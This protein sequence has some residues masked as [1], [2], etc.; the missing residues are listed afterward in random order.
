VAKVLLYMM[1]SLAR[2]HL[3]SGDAFANLVLTSLN[4]SPGKE[5]ELPLSYFMD[6]YIG[7]Q[8]ILT[9]LTGR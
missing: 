7:L 6:D 5:T 9:A 4:A 3:R 2:I 8:E 1:T